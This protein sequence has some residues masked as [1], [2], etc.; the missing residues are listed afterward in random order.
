MTADTRPVNGYD[1]PLG[2]RYGGMVNTDGLL[3]NWLNRSENTPGHRPGSRL[4][5]VATGLLALLGVAL[6]I[7]S[8]TAQ[9]RYVLAE[10][11]QS[12]ASGLEAGALDIGMMIFSLLA[13]GLARAGQSARVERG[14]VIA[15]AA[16]SALMNVAAAN[17]GSP[18][19]VLAWV[20]PPVFLAVV[21]DRVVVVVRRHVLGVREG[22]SPWANGSRVA[23]Y[24]LRLVL[25]APSTLSG[26]R[27]A[28]LAATPLPAAATVPAIASTGEDISEEEE[29]HLP[30]GKQARLI[31]LAQARHDLES[32]PLEQVS[33]LATELAPQVPIHAGTARRVLIARV[34]E[35]QNGANR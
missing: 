29:P 18:R 35:I 23:L 1:R 14:L 2:E 11:H 9:Y 24:A 16:G 21:V 13:L 3:W 20:A 7:V 8:I 32:I 28:V 26:G 25:A 27:R 19:S 34:R 33:G 17:A 22:R 15:C 5:A 30:E 10:R 12:V 31:A 6:L 4:I